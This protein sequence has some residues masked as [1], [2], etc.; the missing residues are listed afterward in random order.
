MYRITA[1]AV[2]LLHFAFVA[3]VVG[4]G[5]LVVW[6]RTVAWLHVPLV[7]YGSSL[8][9][10][11]WVCPLTP[12]EQRLRIAAGDAGYTGGFID[13]YL[14]GILYPNSWGDIHV[15]LGVLLLAGNVALYARAFR[16][17]GA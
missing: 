1:D 14:G 7:L 6:R 12:L 16:R 11:G 10:F 2:M 3:F 4:G 5:L 9:F 17:R 13:H 8:E 15:W